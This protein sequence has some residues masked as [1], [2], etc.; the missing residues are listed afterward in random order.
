MQNNGLLKDERS[1]ELIAPME[2]THVIPFWA[3]DSEWLEC[4]IERD[5][6]IQLISVSPSIRR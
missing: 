2:L 1:E 5:L 4:L 3:S 6:N